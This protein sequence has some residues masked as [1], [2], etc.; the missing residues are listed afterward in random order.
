MVRLIFE[1]GGA[2]RLARNFRGAAES[3]RRL[4]RDAADEIVDYVRTMRA[5]QIT[6]GGARGG[7][8]YPELKRSTLRYKELRYP[9]KAILRRTDRMFQAA[10]VGGPDSGVKVE[11]DSVEV[12]VRLA[13]AVIHQKGF[14]KGRRQLAAREIDKPT[15]RDLPNLVEIVR[16][17]GTRQLERHGF[18]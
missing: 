3:V 2:E 1:V 14:K 9:G 15:E 4:V 11:D 10:A 6:S 17:E 12:S 5:A 7:K 8:V 16:R 18:R 13:R